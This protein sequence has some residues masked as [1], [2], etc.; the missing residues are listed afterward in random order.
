MIVVVVVGL[1]YL[2]TTGYDFA[3]DDEQLVTANPDIRSGSPLGLFGK[4]F[5]A[6]GHGSESRRVAYYRPLAALSLWLDHRVWG[7]SPRGL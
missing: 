3:W 6:A 4:S 7:M 5:L 2:P 1:F